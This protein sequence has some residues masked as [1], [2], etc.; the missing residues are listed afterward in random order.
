MYETTH[1]EFDGESESDA[2]AADEVAVQVEAGYEGR[3][4]VG[5]ATGTVRE[6]TSGESDGQ[7]RHDTAEGLSVVVAGSRSISEYVSTE[8][9]G[10]LVANAIEESEFAVN[11]VVSGTARGVDQVGEKWADKRG[12]SIEHFPADWD[13]HGRAAGPI[14]NQEMVE[15]ADAVVAVHVGASKGTADLIEKARRTLGDE[16]VSVVNI[17][18][19]ERW[20]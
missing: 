18:G 14:R 7:Y 3:S 8:G 12:I 5:T 10:V 13:E 11:E 20:C 4:V 6:H 19:L 15:Y 2:D 16:R 17:G 9:A 1:T